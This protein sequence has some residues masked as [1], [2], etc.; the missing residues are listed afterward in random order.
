MGLRTISGRRFPANYGVDRQENVRN[1]LLIIYHSGR[2]QMTV[3]CGDLV[4]MTGV[5]DSAGLERV[6]AAAANLPEHEPWTKEQVKA[7]CEQVGRLPYPRLLKVEHLVGQATLLMKVVSQMGPGVTELNYAKRSNRPTFNA[8]PELKDEG[9]EV[10]AGMCLE[11]PVM[12]VLDEGQL[13]V[14]ANLGKGVQR[15][16]KQDPEESDEAGEGEE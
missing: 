11:V 7:L 9:M 3:R 16:V 4:S 15:A 10:P 1:P 6:V 14:E 5:T 2:A 13:K 8:L 12:L